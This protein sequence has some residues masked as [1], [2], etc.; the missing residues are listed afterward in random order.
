M[1]T[2]ELDV[3]KNI[4]RIL[5]NEG[6]E[7]LYPPQAEAIPYA[8]AGENLVL[9]IPTASGKSLVAYLAVLKSVLEKGGKALYI[10][11]LRALASE[12]FDD[13]SAFQSLGI[14]VVISTGDLDSSDPNLK[15]FDVIVATSEKADSLL[16]HKSK[17]LEKLSIIV[18][19]EVHL[20]NDPSRGP[21]LEVILARFK[22][23]NPTAQIIALS[24]TIQNSEEIAEWLNARHV[25]SDWRPVELHEGVF[26][27]DEIEFKDQS[28]KKLDRS[29]PDPLNSLV[30]DIVNQGGQALIFVNTRRSTESIA[31]NV[32]KSVR[33]LLATG[34][35]KDLVKLSK[36]LVRGPEANSVSKMLAEVLSRGCAYHHAGLSNPQRKMVEN[37]FKT[38]NIKCIVATPTLAAGINLPARRVIVRD[39]YRYDSS[40]A[41][42]L[43]PIPILEIK[44][45]MGRAGRP[46]YDTVGEAILIAKNQSNKDYIF[47][48][49]IYQDTEPIYSKLSIES[50]L[51]THVLAAVATD[52]VNSED[53]LHKFLNNTFL[54]YQESVLSIDEKLNSSLEFLNREEFIKTG[55]RSR[56]GDRKL[57]ATEFGRRTSQLYIDPLSAVK[58]KQ[59]LSNSEAVTLTPLS[60]LH[61]ISATP[62]MLTLYMRSGDYGWIQNIVTNHPE[63]F[64]LPIPEDQNDYE[65]FL[66]EV[67][68]AML[69]V[70]WIQEL[71]EDQIIAKY[72]VGPGDIY[73]KVD[74]AEWLL[75][76]MRE[77]GRLFSYRNTRALNELVQRIRYGVKKDLLD[78]T[79][80]K[81]I[82]RVR[83]RALAQ[84]GYR[85][86]QDIVGIDVNK[87]AQV[88]TI[89][90][91]IATDIK[92]QLGEK[93]SGFKEVKK[94]YD[95]EIEG[96]KLLSDYD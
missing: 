44:Q 48:R 95:D 32:S 24:A 25:K 31:R 34:E 46:K 89:G 19:D 23:L 7:K 65:W 12:K 68:T 67:K 70:D 75:H 21:T 94:V 72:F 63:E 61:A 85:K 51:R 93:V 17:W 20:I 3:D 78:L 41:G 55:K 38:G 2:S 50:A 22:Q 26:Y 71:P 4:I 28:V 59:S 45:M 53:E 88:P 39:I 6:I 35:L 36:S 56:S 69:M 54:A 13:L 15:N 84:A 11:P 74:T 87:L 47:D 76:A 86:T 83:A 18:A 66:S 80:L 5:K 33:P 82:G 29:S 64:L 10:V 79:N 73:S 96:Q 81:G 8:L 9:A 52:I 62:D 30:I 91:R 14:N 90:K 77:L 43:V 40:G 60:F 16:R 27:K 49:Y 37:N 1:K 58:I 42:K 57:T 92:L